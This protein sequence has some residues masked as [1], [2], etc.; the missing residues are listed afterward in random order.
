MGN[1]QLQNPFQQLE[2]HQQAPQRIKKKVLASAKFS[3][4]VLYMLDLFISKPLETISVLFKTDQT[5]Q[6]TDSQIHLS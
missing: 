2:Q 1:R 6:G 4:I 3:Y 5:K